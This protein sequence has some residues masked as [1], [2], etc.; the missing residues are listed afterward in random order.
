[1]NPIVVV[2]LVSVV[3]AGMY[4]V[5][6]GLEKQA[7]LAA[8]HAD[9]LARQHA[10]H[11]VFVHGEIDDGGTDIILVNHGPQAADLVQI[12]AYNASLADSPLIGTW[13]VSYELPPLGRFNLTDASAPPP[14]PAAGSCRPLGLRTAGFPAVRRHVQGRDVGGGHI[15]DII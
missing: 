7:E 6:D 2:G 15:R 13:E 3:V 4:A 1:M 10:E 9:M 5:Y 8:L 12:R 11:T 14:A